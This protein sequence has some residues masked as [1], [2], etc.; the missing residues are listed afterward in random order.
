MTD[1]DLRHLFHVAAGDLD[2]PDP[3]AV[4][5]AWRAGTRRRVGVRSAVIASVAAT[6]VT[7]VGVALLDQPA[8]RVAPAPPVSSPTATATAQG[9]VAV[10]GGDYEGAE[11]WRA[12]SVRDEA[13]LPALSVAQL[14]STIDLES[15][16]VD[17]VGEPVA[18]LFAGRGERAFALTASRRVV[19]ID[20]SSLAQ[21]TDEAGNGRNPLSYYSLSTDGLRAFFIQ[22]S[23]LAILDL[24]SGDWTSIDTPDWLAEGARWAMSDRIWVPDSL[25]EDSAGTLYRL[26][27]STSR[28]DV[29]WVRGWTG[30][31][32]EP[33]GPVAAGRSGTAQGAFTRITVPGGMSY[34]QGVMVER[35]DERSVLTLD[36]GGPG[37]GATRAKG[38][39]IALGW[40][41]RDTVLFSSISSEAQRVLA[42]RVGTPSVLLV[43]EIVGPASITA[44]AGPS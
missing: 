35:A 34:P 10:R 15:A 43:S 22:N 42:W 41:D 12:P 37:D 36:Y 1:S 28:A 29:D 13:S 5:R 25:G 20:T 21:V 30:P 8:G 4:D 3:A 11:V 9:P 2:G 16:R 31:G 33:W 38:C 27:G 26:D 23:S 18:A 24:V 32:D 14:P 17:V 7:V 19:E 44:L 39:C 6:A 40:L